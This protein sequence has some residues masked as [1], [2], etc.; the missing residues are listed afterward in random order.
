L[1][2]INFTP[3]PSQLYP[4]VPGHITTALEL[5]VPS[6]SHR[7]ADFAELYAST[8]AALRDLLTIPPDYHIWFVGSATE[9]ME[10]IIQNNVRN[11][12]HHLVTGA[13][14]H[15]FAD[16]ALGFGR[17]VSITEAPW[18]DGLD[19]DV[20]DI[21]SSAELIAITQNDTSSGTSIDPAAIRRLHQRYPDKLIAVDIVSSTPYADL[22][23]AS[24]DCAFFS[25]QKGFGMPAGLGVIIASPRALQRAEVLKAEGIPIG[26]FHSFPELAQSEA[27]GQTPETPNVLAIYVL[28]AVARDLAA[29]GLTRL[30]TE[31]ASQAQAIH[32]YF[33]Q[34]SNGSILATNP[35]HRS[36]TVIVGQ[37]GASSA[38]VIDAL[39]ARGIKLGKGYGKHKD[40]H[41]RIANFPAHLGHTD[42]LL[43]MLEEH[44]PQNA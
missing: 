27:K 38:P 24:T 35:D 31:L 9:A 44:F 30:R 42:Q 16:Q 11:H 10:R 32:A 18:G 26:A 36:H 25:V 13:F 34:H 5:G 12:S 41:I 43:S 14:G 19:L 4:T 39:S 2:T 23:I 6:I 3:G 15:K 20:L 40:T 33:D 17:L 7:S 8:G 21:P 22:D 29:Y 28:G 37:L 1:N